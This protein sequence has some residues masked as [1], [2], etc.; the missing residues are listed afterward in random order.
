MENELH[1]IGIDVAKAKL[2]VDMFG[3]MAGIEKNLTIPSPDTS[4]GPL[5]A[6]MT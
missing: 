4:A 6:A 3:L 5:V 2:D 1:F